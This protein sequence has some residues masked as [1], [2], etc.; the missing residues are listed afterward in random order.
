MRKIKVYNK[1]VEYTAEYDIINDVYY[2]YD[3]YGECIDEA[4]NVEVGVL[5]G[6]ESQYTLQRR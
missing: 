2:I 3:S 1:G 4:I 6:N 5:E